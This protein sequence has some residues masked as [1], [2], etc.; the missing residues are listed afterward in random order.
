ML[1]KTQVAKVERVYSTFLEEFPGFRELA[2]A[3][4]KDISQIFA[5]LGLVKRAKYILQTAQLIITDYDGQLPTAPD[6]LIK[7]PGIGKYTANAIASFAYN[8][9]FPVVDSTIAR[10]LKRLLGYQTSKEAWEDKITWQVADEFLD[11]RNSARHNYA[12]IDLAALICIPRDPLC[13]ICPL[14][15]WCIQYR[16]STI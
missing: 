10:V 2:S 5:W 16:V 6:V 15:H 9:A 8:Q 7:L 3:S 14:Q 11:K 13:S 1:Q 4:E 12:L